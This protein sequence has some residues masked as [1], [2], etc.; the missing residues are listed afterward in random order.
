[1]FVDVESANF[2]NEGV[3]DQAQA[4]FTVPHAKIDFLDRTL[5]NSI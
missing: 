4:V 1:M 5:R 2:E 3:Y